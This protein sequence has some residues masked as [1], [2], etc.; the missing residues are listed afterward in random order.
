MLCAATNIKSFS[1]LNHLQTVSL[2]FPFHCRIGPTEF[3]VAWVKSCNLAHTV[4][5]NKR[6]LLPDDLAAVTKSEQDFET[7][8]HDILSCGRKNDEPR[9]YKETVQVRHEATKP[10][11]QGILKVVDSRLQESQVEHNIMEKER[12]EWDTIGKFLYNKVNEKESQRSL[13]Q[14]KQSLQDTEQCLRKLEDDRNSL[15]KQIEE[16][17]INQAIEI[18]EKIAGEIKVGVKDHALDQQAKTRQADK[19]HQIG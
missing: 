11:D 12:E 17:K 14:L 1:I 8:L 15:L 16:L 18:T 5:K 13:N 6:I 3:K 19:R 9:N 2:H 10:S 4:V 7:T